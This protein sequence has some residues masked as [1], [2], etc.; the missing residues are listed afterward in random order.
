L[1]LTDP[2]KLAQVIEK[3]EESFGSQDKYVL[4]MIIDKFTNN[5][6]NLI[7]IKDDNTPWKIIFQFYK[8]VKQQEASKEGLGIDPMKTNDSI[9]NTA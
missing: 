6:T 3:C 9:S 4:R 2:Q 8:E 1:I 5:M 7:P